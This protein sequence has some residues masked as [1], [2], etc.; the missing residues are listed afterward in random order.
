MVYYRNKV[1]HNILNA[2]TSKYEIFHG[3]S[4]VNT[5]YNS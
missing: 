3:K 5:V 1:E 2:N 4:N